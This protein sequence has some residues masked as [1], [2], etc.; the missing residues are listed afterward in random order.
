MVSPPQNETVRRN[1][2]VHGISVGISCNVQWISDR[3]HQIL[4]HLDLVFPCVRSSEQDINLKFLARKQIYE[5]PSDARNVFQYNDITVWETEDQLYLSDNLSIVQFSPYSGTGVGF[6]HPSLH[7]T[8]SELK[9]DL[10]LYSLLIVLRHFEMYAMHAAG[11]VQ[12]KTGCLFIAESNS[13]KSTIAFSLLRQGWDYLSDDSV[14][15]RSNGESIVALS[16]RRELCLDPDAVRYFP[17]L[18]KHWQAYP[19]TDGQK[20]PLDVKTLYPNQIVSSCIPRV[21][22]IPEIVSDQ[23]SQLIQLNKAET[24]FSLSRQSAIS[25]MGSHKISG[26]MEILKRLINQSRQYRLLMG[27]DLKGNPA[28]VSHILSSIGFRK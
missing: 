28:L 10:V 27:R 22:I 18:A 24:L 25:Q 11:L 2:S 9:P 17:E 15:L 23:T 8:P 3:I 16:L 12:N 5:I 14:L 26:H 6:I 4:D 21:L 19:S 13:G 20:R 7:E 1:Y